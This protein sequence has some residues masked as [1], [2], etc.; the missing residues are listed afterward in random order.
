MDENEEDEEFGDDDDN[1]NN[2]DDCI[3]IFLNNQL[4]T[5]NNTKDNSN[6]IKVLK[7]GILNKNE[8]TKK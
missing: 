7:K 6:T 8:N 1:I 4:I 2:N 3:N 5:I